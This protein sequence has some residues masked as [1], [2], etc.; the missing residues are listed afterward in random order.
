MAAVF[1]KLT[2]CDFVRVFFSAWTVLFGNKWVKVP[3][4]TEISTVYVYCVITL[5]YNDTY[6]YTYDYLSSI[7]S[8]IA[9]KYIVKSYK[10]RTAGT[11]KLF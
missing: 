6:D 10:V 9:P 5:L 2:G 8:N 7:K 11:A 3:L 4:Y 1:N